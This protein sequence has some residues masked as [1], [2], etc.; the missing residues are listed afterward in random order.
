MLLLIPFKGSRKLIPA[1]GTIAAS[2]FPLTDDWL[3]AVSYLQ[4]EPH[5][6]GYATHFCLKPL[7]KIF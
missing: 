2:L 4:Q 3:S 5:E 7:K 6:N 1:I